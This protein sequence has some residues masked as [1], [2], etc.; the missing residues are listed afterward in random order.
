[1]QSNAPTVAAY[2]A[3]LPSD[4]RAAIEQVR[5][6]I[7]K[8]LDRGPDGKSGFTEG[9]QYGMIGYAVPHSIFPHGYH[10]DPKQ[11][12]PY[13]ALG[14][15]KNHMAL[16]LMC[17]YIHAE[18]NGWFGKEWAKSGKK[19]DMGKACIRFN[20]VEDLALNV[21]GELLQRVTVKKDLDHYAAAMAA[22]GKDITGKKIA[23][24]KKLAG[25]APAKK[26]I[27]TKKSANSAR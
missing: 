1:M 18:T 6:V 13:I 10:C 4:R 17:T 25:K 14:S 20:K 27:A 23:P 24:A 7:L 8:N 9:M 11:P 5:A 19:L 16:H 15:Q 21:I 3:S 22:M 26:K 12:L 2:L